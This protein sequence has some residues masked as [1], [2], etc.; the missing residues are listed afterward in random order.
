MLNFIQKIFPKKCLGI[1]VGTSYIKIVELCRSGRQKKLENYGQIFSTQK[2]S[3]GKDDNFIFEQDT[4]KAIRAVIE[5]AG[6]KTNEVVFSIPD[7]ATFFTN[8]E[9]PPMSKDELPQAIEYEARRYVPVPVEELTFDWQI[10]EG[11]H[12]KKEQKTSYKI[13]L[14]AV[15]N[16]VVR[17]YKE[18]AQLANLELVSLEA[19]TFSLM[20]ALAREGEKGPVL[21]MDIGAKSTVCSI[22]DGK[23]L[24]KSHSLD[25]CG[26]AFTSAIMHE[27]NIDF[28][29]AEKLKKQC[30]INE[31]S[32]REILLPLMDVTLGGIKG[33]LKNE[34][35]NIERV[36]ISGGTSLLPGLKEYFQKALN[37]KVEI[38]NPFLGLVYPPILD[39]TLSGMGPSFAI[40]VGSALRGLEA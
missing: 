26:N 35:R 14:V 12:S 1:D 29:E 39:E 33:I 23:I 30:G 15:P 10:I 20:R 36:I 19:E 38:S 6:I 16:E 7:F 37:K 9:L 13:L 17:Q 11:Q 3:A 28:K 32:I 5:E 21:L 4:A 34:G 2:P 24:R 18:I 31:E 27:L 8:L 22:V 25:M 40:T